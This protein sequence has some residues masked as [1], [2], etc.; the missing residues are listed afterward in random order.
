MRKTK[1]QTETI[2]DSNTDKDRNSVRQNEKDCWI[3][4]LDKI[5]N[6]KKSADKCNIG[7]LSLS[8]IIYLVSHNRTYRT[9]SIDK[10]CTNQKEKKITKLSLR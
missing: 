9:F 10:R 4:I 5:R 3:E 7:K 2:R 6:I 8:L 1:R